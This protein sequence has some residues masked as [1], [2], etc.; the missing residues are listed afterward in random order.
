MHCFVL[1]LPPRSG[2]LCVFSLSTVFMPFKIY[3][4]AAVSPRCSSIIAP[5]QICPI[6]L[7]IPLP[8]MSGAEPCTGSKRDGK[9]LSGLIFADGAIPIVPVVAGP[10][11]DKIS[12]KRFEPTT[13]LNLPGLSTK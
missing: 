3:S 13:T 4:L 2:V 5:A 11:S 7:A 12:P 8:V 9:F 1:E 10:R 6:G